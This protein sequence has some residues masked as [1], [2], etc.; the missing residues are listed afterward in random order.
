[1]SCDDIIIEVPQEVIVIEMTPEGADGKSLN[2]RGDWNSSAVYTYRDMVA[3]QGNS[4]I[5]LKN[6]PA[7]TLPT[8]TEYWMIN[9]A[10]GNTTYWGNIHGTLSN[11]T[12]LVT[13][14]ASKADANAVYTKTEA[15][16]CF[17]IR[18]MPIRYIPKRRQIPFWTQKPMRTAFIRRP[19]Q[20]H[21]WMKRRT[22]Q[23][24]TPRPQPMTFWT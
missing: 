18:R 10:G 11:Q 22:L 20:T 12:D 17:P 15:D 16:A 21:F 7:G 1:M 4:Y 3:Y 2:P 13:A 19:K 14:L 5:A 23:V 8:D 24:F 6:V 9:A